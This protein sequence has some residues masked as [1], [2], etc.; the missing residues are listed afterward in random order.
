MSV[1][2]HD[3]EHNTPG[4]Y[5]VLTHTNK[6]GENKDNGRK[7]SSFDHAVNMEAASNFQTL[8]YSHTNH[9]AVHRQSKSQRF[10][11]DIPDEQFFKPSTLI[12]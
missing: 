12:I 2:I 1:Q 3:I 9:S 7:P 10:T 5:V 11:N 4:A 8:T 6:N